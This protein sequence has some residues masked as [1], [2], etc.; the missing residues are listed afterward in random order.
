MQIDILLLSHCIKNVNI[1][2]ALILDWDYFYI[3]LNKGSN[4]KATFLSPEALNSLFMT[5][6][7]TYN[8][9]I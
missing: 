4:H 2:K 6:C 8:I 1:F 9:Y 7:V 3:A 5:Q